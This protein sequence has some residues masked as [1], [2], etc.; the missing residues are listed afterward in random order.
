MDVIDPMQAD[1]S[2]MQDRQVAVLGFGPVAAVHALCLRDSGVDVYVGIE[3]G[4][5]GRAR[6]EAEGLSVGDPVAVARRCDVVAAVD[7]G[8]REHSAVAQ[9]ADSLEPGDAVLLGR[10]VLP[11]PWLE[12]VPEGVDLAAIELIAAPQRARAEYIDGRGVPALVA[13]LRDASGFSE[14]VMAAY[15]AALGVL[16]AGAIR[17]EPGTA[18]S[19]RQ[20][21]R[22]GVQAAVDRVVE[23]SQ[24][25]LTDAGYP[26]EIAYLACV[27]E[28]RQSVEELYVGGLAAHHGPGGHVASVPALDSALQQHLSQILDDVHS[29][30]TQARDDDGEQAASRSAGADAAHAAEVAGRE[31]RARM[32]WLRG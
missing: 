13:V 27:H 25:L 3:E 5:R 8:E 10:D 14:P 32:P 2:L 24:H 19:A 7:A 1:L 4:S 11:G 21:A 28:L 29:G 30:R 20:F 6:A 16:R 12:S 17:I 18:W 31:L 15:A 26:P 22:H 9:I 23:Q